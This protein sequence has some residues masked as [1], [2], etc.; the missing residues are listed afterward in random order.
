MEY[1][2]LVKIMKS[3]EKASDKAVEKENGKIFLGFISYPFAVSLSHFFCTKY[4]CSHFCYL[5][6]WIFM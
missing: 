2:I 3:K 6:L 4:M 1:C 5:S